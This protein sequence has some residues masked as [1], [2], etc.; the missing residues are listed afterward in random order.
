MIMTLSLL[1]PLCVCVCV[2]YSA[3]QERRWD[4]PTGPLTTGFPELDC[5]LVAHLK[6][7]G[8]QLLVRICLFFG[9]WSEPLRFS[10]IAILQRLICLLYVFFFLQTSH[11]R[12]TNS[13]FV[14]RLGTFGPLRCG[15]MYALDRLLREVRVLQVIRRLIKDRPTSTRHLNEGTLCRGMLTIRVKLAP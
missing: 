5:T 14:Q 10:F 4:S 12:N 7:C 13:S 9:F 15:E 3:Q 8:I 6:N 1:W 11:S 2:Y